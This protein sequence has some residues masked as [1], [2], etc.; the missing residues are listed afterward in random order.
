MG[1]NI[2]TLTDQLF[3]QIERL[4]N[5]ELKGEQLE[6]E[7]NRA[8]SITQVSGQ[9]INAGNLLLDAQKFKTEYGLTDSPL[10]LEGT[11]D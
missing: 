8:K 1:N 2:Q 6:A 3:K 11:N 9:I 7:I 5:T 10:L 4:G